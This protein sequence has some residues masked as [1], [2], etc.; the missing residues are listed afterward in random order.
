MIFV[1]DVGNTNIKNGLY[2]G[3]TLKHSWR[4][5][6]N[7]K[8]T[9]DELGIK[10][11][12]FFQYV[13][14]PVSEVEGIIGS[15]VMPSINYT[16]EHMCRLYF[17]KTPLFVG[18]GVKTGINIRYDS[19]SNLGADRICSA[20][21]ATRLYGRPLIVIDFG[22]ASTFNVIDANGDFLGGAICP[23]IKIAAR[24]LVDNTARL[25]KV[26]LIKPAS[27][28]GKNTIAGMQAGLLY[29]Y[30]GQIEYLIKKI[31]QQMGEEDVKIIA[32]GGMAS[33][34]VEECA[35]RIIL[36]S[37]LTLDGLRMIYDL[38]R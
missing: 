9:A 38:N 20:V 34:I 16:I 31:M 15:S 11:T 5:T 25:P 21:A 28:I 12:S 10:M 6:S 1:M 14:V 18:P 36:N 29:G 37:T 24:A 30:I 35:Y 32:T 19:P 3:E 13:N 33:L 27:P 23:G 22:T 8:E 26:E 4:T 2:E 17:G 7:A